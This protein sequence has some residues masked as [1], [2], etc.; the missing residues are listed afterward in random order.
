MGSVLSLKD[1]VIHSWLLK[2]P[3]L[4]VHPAV[5]KTLFTA[6]LGSQQYPKS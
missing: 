3:V 6:S 4:N 1:R 2:R 5:P